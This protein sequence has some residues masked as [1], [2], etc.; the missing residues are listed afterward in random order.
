M[1]E[2]SELIFEQGLMDIPLV[3]SIYTWSNN[4]DHPTWS[5]LDRF[6][7]YLDWEAHFLDVSQKRLPRV[8]SD[9]FPFLLDCN[10]VTS[11]IGYF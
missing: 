8:L 5:R 4:C 1:S 2:F 9:N 3:G 7:L 6:L 11:S 10:D